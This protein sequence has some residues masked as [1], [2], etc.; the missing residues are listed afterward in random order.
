M[1]SMHTSGSL[2]GEQQS[3][4]TFIRTMTLVRSNEKPRRSGALLA[5]AT[6]RRPFG[7]DQAC[8]AATTLTVR[9]LFGPLVV[10]STLPSTS[11][12]SV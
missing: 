8:S 12:N 4:R 2:A 7:M 1:R 3:S 11:A 9:R 10:N 5:A 6:H